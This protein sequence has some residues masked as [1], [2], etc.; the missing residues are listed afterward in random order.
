[1][2]TRFT[3][4]I[5][6]KTNCNISYAGIR[7]ISYNNFHV[8]FF[9]NFAERYVDC[10][11]DQVKNFKNP[12]TVLL[13]AFAIIMLNTDLHNASI[14]QERKMKLDDFVRNLRGLYHCK[15]FMFI[16]Q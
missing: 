12:E 15:H 9:Q 2:N 16:F 14:K 7:G 13:L 10:N 11:P 4:Y 5:I 3:E 8:L 1:M 6:T